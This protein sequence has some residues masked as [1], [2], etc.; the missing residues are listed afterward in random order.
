VFTWQPDKPIYSLMTVRNP[1]TLSSSG[2]MYRDHQSPIAYTQ[3]IYEQGEVLSV[4]DNSISS[5][6]LLYPTVIENGIFKLKYSS[7]FKNESIV[8]TIYNTAGQLVKKV[9]DSSTEIDVSKLSNGL[10]FVK[11]DSDLGYFTKKIIIKK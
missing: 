6:L 7:E 8:L 11:I 10:Y 5:E 2:I 4:E 9:S 3:E 1:V